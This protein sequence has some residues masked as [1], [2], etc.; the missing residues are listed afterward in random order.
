MH[1]E[2]YTA[3]TLYENTN[4]DTPKISNDRGN[5]ESYGRNTAV[6]LVYDFFLK[7]ICL[8]VSSGDKLFQT[9][10]AN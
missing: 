8:S 9:L 3:F 7:W 5:K 10:L 1:W 2:I 4:K 6:I